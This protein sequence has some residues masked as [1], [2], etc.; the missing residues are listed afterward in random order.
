MENISN[1]VV[2]VARLVIIHAL[3]AQQN[4]ALT[5][6]LAVVEDIYKTANANNAIVRA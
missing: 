5:V 4:Q 1:K 2:E 6:K 3:S